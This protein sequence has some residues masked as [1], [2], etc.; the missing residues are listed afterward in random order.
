MQVKLFE[1]QINSP[2]MENA[3]C[4][5]SLLDPVSHPLPIPP[6]PVYVTGFLPFPVHPVIEF[7]HKPLTKHTNIS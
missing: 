6:V 2:Y 5:F 1:V 7:L 3:P 4:L